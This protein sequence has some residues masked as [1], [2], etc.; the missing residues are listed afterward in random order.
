MTPLGG[1]RYRVDSYV[2]AQNGFGA[3]IRQHFHLVAKQLPGKWQ[4]ESLRFDG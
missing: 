2:D 4:L 3:M 1:G